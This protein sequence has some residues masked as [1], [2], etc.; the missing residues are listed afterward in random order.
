MLAAIIL[1]SSGSFVMTVQNQ[2]R[3]CR[4]GLTELDPQYTAPA[5]P[6]VDFEVII[7]VPRLCRGTADTML[8]AVM[9]AEARTVREK[10]MIIIVRL[11][12]G[13]ERKV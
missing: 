5:A 8:L 10:C 13:V 1:F 3:L 7:L 12:E 9:N 2:V 6:L 4:R 11:D